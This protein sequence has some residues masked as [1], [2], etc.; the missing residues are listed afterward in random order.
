MKKGISISLVVLLVTALFRFSIATHFCGGEA[1]ASKVTLSGRTAS[2][3]M[4]DEGEESPVRGTLLKT[5]CCDDVITSYAIDNNFTPSFSVIPRL[6]LHNLHIFNKPGELPVLSADV[7]QSLYT[8]IKPPGLLTVTN[9]DLSGIC[10]F[11]I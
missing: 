9:V 7:I 4:E 3:G 2:C 1:V 6:F 10:V 8:S 11:R 5:H